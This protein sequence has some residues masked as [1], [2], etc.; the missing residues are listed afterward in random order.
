MQERPPQPPEGKLIE[1][2]AAHLDIS[3]REAA[4]RAGL[5]Y[6]RWR[7]IV[8][9]YQNGSQGSYAE[10]RGPVKTVARMATTVGIT[11]EQM[12]TEGQRPDVADFMRQEPGTRPPEI[13]FAGDDAEALRPYIDELERLAL[14]ALA[15]LFGGDLPGDVT[16]NL[17]VALSVPGRLLF[18]DSPAQARLWDDTRLTPKERITLLAKYRKNAAQAVKP[19]RRIG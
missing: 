2:A 7:Q 16:G 18:P 8:Q 1:D 9:G 17:D 12:E 5:S 19:E 11:P 6:G 3:I 10:V 15:S 4:R 13:D 14:D